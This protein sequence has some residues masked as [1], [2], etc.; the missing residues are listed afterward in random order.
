M[1]HKHPQDLGTKGSLRI[2][3][4]LYEGSKQLILFLKNSEELEWPCSIIY[5]SASV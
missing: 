5:F 1:F 4:W 2:T 3:L